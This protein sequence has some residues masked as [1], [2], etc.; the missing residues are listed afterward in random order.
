MFGSGISE[1]IHAQDRKFILSL[2][3]WGNDSNF[4]II[5]ADPDLREFFINNLISIILING[6]DGADLDWEFP[7]SETDR[8]NLNLLVSEMR[9]AERISETKRLRFAR[10]VSESGNSQSRSAPS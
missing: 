1:V 6:Y 3:G 8:A 9:S 7:D 10:S 2:G 5:C 4:E